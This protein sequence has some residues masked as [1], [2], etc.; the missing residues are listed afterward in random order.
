MPHHLNHPGYAAIMWRNDLLDT[1]DASLQQASLQTFQIHHAA[2]A[3]S[4]APLAAALG[5]YRSAL[6]LWSSAHGVSTLAD[7][8]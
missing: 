2:A 8:V 5:P 3:M 1:T 4:E 7:R 6:M